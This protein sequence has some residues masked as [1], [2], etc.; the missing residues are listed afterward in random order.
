MRLFTGFTPKFVIIS[1]TCI[2]FVATSLSMLLFVLFGLGIIEM[3]NVAVGALASVMA[4]LSKLMIEV[5]K[6][7]GQDM[8]RL[9]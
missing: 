3:S 5:V 9:S 4:S 7:T 6:L 1:V 2:F 8:L